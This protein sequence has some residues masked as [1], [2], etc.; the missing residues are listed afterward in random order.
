MI[1]TNS[2]LKIFKQKIKTENRIK[3]YL[4]DPKELG[5]SELNK[6]DGENRKFLKN[7]TSIVDTKIFKE[8]KFF[9]ITRKENRKLH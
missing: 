2:F 3:L 7:K 4:V 9:E 8:L 1:F 5:I 6:N